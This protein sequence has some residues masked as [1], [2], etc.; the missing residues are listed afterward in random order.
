MVRQARLLNKLKPVAVLAFI[1][2][3]TQSLPTVPAIYKDAGDI[4]FI[5]KQGITQF[6]GM[7]FSGWQYELYANGDTTAIVPYYKGR[8]NGFAKAWYVNKQLKESGEFREGKKEGMHKAWWP[9]GKP[10]F[11][12]EFKHGVYNGHVK[13]WFATGLVYKEF[14][15]KNGREAGMQRQY[16]D[17]GKI[18]FN[19]EAKDGRYYGYTGVK[20]CVN[21]IDS[22]KTT[23]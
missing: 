15:Y 3:C 6:N 20:N 17:N 2:A 4:G 22:I 14:I 12:R 8:E 11:V 9:D 1:T 19:Y 10:R 18:Q 23:D 16:F 13:E 5:T 21:V 7:P